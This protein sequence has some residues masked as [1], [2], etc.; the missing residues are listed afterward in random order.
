MTTHLFTVDVE[1][2]FQVAALEPYVPRATWS[3]IPSRV[4]VGV[5]VLLEALD[6]HTARGTF[7]ALGIVAQRCP[8]VVRKIAGAGHEIASHG[9]SHCNIAALGPKAFREEA[10][11]TRMVLEDLTGQPVTGFRAPNFS[12]LPQCEW[13]FDALIEAGYQYDSSIFPGRAGRRHEPRYE[14]HE[15]RRA[16]GQLIELPLT[17]AD[18]AGMRIPAAGGAWFRLLPYQLSALALRQA[19]QRQHAAVF[20]VH[21]WELDA[22]QPRLRVQPLTRLRHYGGLAKSKARLHRLLRE[23][24]FTSIRDW[25]ASVRLQVSHVL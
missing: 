7:F 20:Y 8:D 25:L 1:E 15:I 5:D 13:A 4:E 21:P 10:E 14:P 16:A 24:R 3:S 11:R 18:L 22:D 23:F 17:C 9:W 19:E 12:L 6:R 2:Y